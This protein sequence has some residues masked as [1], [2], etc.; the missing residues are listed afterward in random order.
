MIGT[1]WAQAAGGAGAAAP[2][3]QFVPLVLIFGVFYVLIIRPQQQKQ[4]DLQN[5]LA[6]LRLNDEVLTNGGI[7]GR[8]VALGEKIVTVEIAPN[9]RVRVDRAQIA[10]LAND[11]SSDKPKKEKEKGQ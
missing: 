10:A 7:Y 3:M 11:L 2:Y 8:I 5:V 1:A 9:V 6:N 4:K